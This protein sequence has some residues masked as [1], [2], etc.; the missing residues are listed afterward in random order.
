MTPLEQLSFPL[1]GQDSSPIPILTLKMMLRPVL[2]HVNC[3]NRK[4]QFRNNRELAFTWLRRFSGEREGANNDKNDG[5]KESVGLNISAPSNDKVSMPVMKPFTDV[6]G[7]KTTDEVYVIMYTC[8]ICET[9]SAKKISKHS[10]H[11]GCVIVRC[12]SCKNL[13]LIADHLG[14]VEQKG[15]TI[16]KF[17]A[18]EGGGKFAFRDNVLEVSLQDITGE[19]GVLPTTK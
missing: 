19:E 7:V 1:R 12:P 6:P 14:V 13:H 3:I 5:S 2:A 16:E 11:H 15:W 17:L 10:Y 8:K 9:R 18:E 4:I